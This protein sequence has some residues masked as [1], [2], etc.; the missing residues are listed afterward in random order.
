MTNSLEHGPIIET[1]GEVFAQETP[2][3]VMKP[4]G[5]L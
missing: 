5:S 2:H 3:Y 1:D 4:E